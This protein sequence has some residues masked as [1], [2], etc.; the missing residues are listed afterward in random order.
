VVS[1]GRRNTKLEP[2]WHGKQMLKSL[3]GVRADGM[4]PWLGFDSVQPNRWLS[5]GSS[6]ESMRWMVLHRPVEP[7]SVTG[8]LKS[9]F[10]CPVTRLTKHSPPLPD[11]FASWDNSSLISLGPAPAQIR[12]VQGRRNVRC[13]GQ[14]AESGIRV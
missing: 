1:M 10:I 3:A 2:A 13:A 4:L 7:A 14:R 11:P 5:R 6:V 12:C 8:H 9:D